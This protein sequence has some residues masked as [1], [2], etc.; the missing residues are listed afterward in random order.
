LRMFWQSFDRVPVPVW[1]T[2]QTPPPSL[3]MVNVDA[4]GMISVDAEA[5][6]ERTIESDPPAETVPPV[7]PPMNV[8]VAPTAVD[9]DEG[10]VTTADALLKIPQLLNWDVVSVALELNTRPPL[11]GY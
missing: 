9:A 6:D 4:M 3:V 2:Y 1:V 10:S 11:D 7:P 8:N 5:A